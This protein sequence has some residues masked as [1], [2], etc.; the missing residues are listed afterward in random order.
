VV[1]RHA[2][3]YLVILLCPL[4][5][6]ADNE[7]AS[8]PAIL[9]GDTLFVHF[10]LAA[11]LS[12]DD[13]ASLLNGETV[14]I[15]CRLELWQKRKL[16]FDRLRIELIA[17][18]DITYDRWTERFVTQAVD[19]RGGDTTFDAAQLDS[20]AS[21]LESSLAFPFELNPIDYSRESYLAYS[22]QLQYLT[23]DK[24]GELK[25]WLFQG[26][27]GKAPPS[28]HQG[29]SLPGKLVSMALSST[30]F[31]NR[32]YLKSST[33]FYPGQIGDTIK[34]PVALN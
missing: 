20:L 24:I 12:P 25:D 10:P 4:L 26:K 34:F 13:S 8:V 17:Y 15:V 18:A 16:W 19:A 22:V 11:F 5:L 14:S 29:Q 31:R 21:N 6:A 7:V 1:R 23:P 32:S 9:A 33:S 30:G 28:G 2:A 27:K 3:I